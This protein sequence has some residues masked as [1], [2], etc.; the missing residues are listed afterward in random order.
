MHEMAICDG[1]VRAS[2]ETAEQAGASRI[3][4]IEVTIGELTEVIEG[5]LQFA[6]EVVRTGTLAEEAT[7]DVTFLPAR[8]RCHECSA[9]FTHGRFDAQCT[10]C[11]SYLVE[12]V[13]GREMRIDAIDID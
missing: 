1:I 9:T 7:L 3:N 8:S 6:F 5:A 10:Q 2:V 4:A 11:G 12:L 13:S